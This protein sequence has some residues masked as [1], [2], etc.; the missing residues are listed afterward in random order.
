MIIINALYIYY[1]VNRESK[2]YQN[3]WLE[4]IKLL[5]AR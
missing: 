5:F 3:I 2:R 1:L 4:T